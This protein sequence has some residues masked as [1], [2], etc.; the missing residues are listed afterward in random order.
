MKR[1]K[2]IWILSCAAL[3]TSVGYCGPDWEEPS[4][5]DAG[6]STLTS[7]VPKGDGQLNS[8]MGK[9]DSGNLLANGPGAAGG[10]DLRDLYLIRIVSPAIFSAS[11]VPVGG[12]SGDAS[13]DTQLF[14]FRADGSGMLAN[15]E[16]SPQS[17]GSL[18]TGDADDGSGITL[19]TSGLYYLGISGFDS[20]PLAGMPGSEIFSMVSRTEVSGPDGPGGSLGR[21]VGWST[22]GETGTYLIELDGCSFAWGCD[23]DA[24]GD[25]EVDVDD[26]SYVLFR[27]GDVDEPGA[28]VNQDGIVDVNDLSFVLFRLGPCP[29]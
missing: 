4:G 16:A 24:N 12:G 9:T 5:D 22:G 15:D 11:T 10:P 6:E 18:L 29:S 17:S 20:G 25:G 27:L 7:Q 26:I 2:L 23:G 28:D 13:F 21:L 8:L 19:T 14:L 3:C 1:D